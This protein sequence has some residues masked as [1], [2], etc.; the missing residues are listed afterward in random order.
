MTPATLV[1]RSSVI[2]NSPALATLSGPRFCVVMVNCTACPM[3]GA[4][5]VITLVV[6][7]TS[8]R[9]STTMAAASLSVPDSSA[10][11]E[12]SVAVLVSV[13]LANGRCTA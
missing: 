13:P 5:G 10:S 4:A 6:A 3:R 2:L 8:M 7:A 9:G 1:F 12:L 11:G